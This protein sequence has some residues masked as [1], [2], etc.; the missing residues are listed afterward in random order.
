M[1]CCCTLVLSQ[2]TSIMYTESQ[3]AFMN[4]Q[5]VHCNLVITLMMGAKQKERYNE[6]SV[7]RK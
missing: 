5:H 4:G 3:A 2:Q 6:M 7:I 1:L